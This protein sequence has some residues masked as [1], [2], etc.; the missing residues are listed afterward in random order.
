M[1][2]LSSFVEM[3]YIIYYVTIIRIPFTEHYYV[4]AFV[5]FW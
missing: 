2:I 3:I 5:S 4:S 1:R